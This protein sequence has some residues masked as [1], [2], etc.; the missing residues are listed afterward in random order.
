M[1]YFVGVD[2]GSHSARAGLFTS[3]GELVAM[4]KQDIQMNNPQT[5]F[6]EQSGEDIWTAVSTCVRSVVSE[7]TDTTPGFTKEMV[8]GVGMDATC[9]LVAIDAQSDE[10]M[11]VSVSGDKAWNIIVWC[12]HR[13]AKEAEMINSSGSNVLKYVGGKVS[14]EMELPKIAWLKGFLTQAG[15][16]D[17]WERMEFF[18][19][20]DYL[21]YRATGVKARSNCSLACKWLFTPSQPGSQQDGCTGWD[22][23]VFSAAGLDDIVATGFRQIGGCLADGTLTV[24]QAGEPVGRGL[25]AAAAADL[26]L[27]EG[28]PVGASVIDAYAGWFGTIASGYSGIAVDRSDPS[29]AGQRLAIIAGTS[30]CHLLAAEHPVFVPGVWG[31]YY[32]VGISGWYMLEGGQSAVGSLIDYVVKSHAAYANLYQQSTASGVSVY[33]LLDDRL[34]SMAAPEPDTEAN[35]AVSRLVKL[36]KSLHFLPDHH[37]NRAPLA[38]P[39]MRGSIVGEALSAP[40]STDALALR[41]LACICG[42]AYGTRAIL[43]AVVAAGGRRVTELLMSGGLSQ[44]QVFTQILAD[45]TGAQVIIP[46]FVD[47]AV[48][49]G[50]AVLGQVASSYSSSSGG[51]VAGGAHAQRL[52]ESMAKMTGDGTAIRPTTNASVLD[53]HERKYRVMLEMQR[54]QLKYRLMVG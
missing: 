29:C 8:R 36:V 25:S 12:D 20:P 23:Q 52:W 30:A 44:G 16:L 7:A 49:L 42:I 27:A 32:N 15:R 26:G 21:S 48:V 51:Q 34:L 2:V 31:P 40:D 24:L 4:H 43:D 54:D 38:D 18:D 53:L 6:Y 39:Q 22:G 19:L 9:S 5:D 17:E 37:G 3:K 28:T 41:Y 46:R 10:P 50:S 35:G 13:A 45:V 33:Q 14:I 11:S 1:E 47:A